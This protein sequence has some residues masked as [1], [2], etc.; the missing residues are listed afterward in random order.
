MMKRMIGLLGVIVLT[1]LPARAGNFAFSVANDPAAGDSVE[2]VVFDELGGVPLAGADV[3]VGTSL[4]PSDATAVTGRADAAGRFVARGWGRGRI[5]VALAAKKGYERVSVSGVRG[6]SITIFLR[7]LAAEERLVL[8]TGVSGGWADATSNKMVRAGL[9]FK[10]LGAMDLLSFRVE[11]LI[12]PLKDKIDV[13]GEREVPSNLVLPEQEVVVFPVTISLDKPSYRLPVQAGRRLR[14]AMLQGEIAAKELT[15]GG[16]QLSAGIL[17]KLKCRKAA[18]SGFM[19]PEDDFKR[20][21]DSDIELQGVHR[22]TPA[23]PPFAADIIVAAVMDPDGSAEYMLPTDVKT[24][25]TADNPSQIKTVTLAAPVRLPAGAVTDVVAA[26]LGKNGRLVSGIRVR[27][28]GKTVEPGKFLELQALADVTKPPA[29][30]DMR[31]PGSGVA[32]VII[33]IDAPDDAVIPVWN[34]YA[35][36]SAGKVSVPLA[37]LPADMKVRRFSVSALELGA[38]FD[39]TTVDASRVMRG[40]TRFSRAMAW[41]KPKRSGG[42]RDE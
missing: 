28:A 38:G 5:Y 24:A 41:V 2:V 9:V 40:L 26:A 10:S 20:E 15:S 25:A 19:V 29:S 8:G 3:L 1:A 14:L 39:E 34:A 35:L 27:G 21:I 30:L 12:S 31:A 4:D 11:S 22:V 37:R 6:S 33:E 13:F 42:D 17:N 23:L 36:P 18:L 7:K 16:G 32:V